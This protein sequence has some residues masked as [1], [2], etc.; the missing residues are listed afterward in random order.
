[1]SSTPWLGGPAATDALSITVSPSG[2]CPA[3]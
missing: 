3:P 1:L 2:V